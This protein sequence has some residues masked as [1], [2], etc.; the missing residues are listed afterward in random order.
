MWLPP[1][2]L[3]AVLGWSRWLVLAL[4]VPGL[5]WYVA[6]QGVRCYE[7]GRAANPKAPIGHRVPALYASSLF[8]AAIAFLPGRL[9]GAFIVAGFVLV[10]LAWWWRTGRSVS[11]TG[12]PVT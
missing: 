2:V 4:L 8:V 12:E 7:E 5:V 3:G 9:V 11:Q 1:A 6:T 10:D